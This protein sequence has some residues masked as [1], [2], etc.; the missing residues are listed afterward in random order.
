[1]SELTTQLLD[2]LEE[3]LNQRQAELLRE[4]GLEVRANNGEMDW[5]V[6]APGGA[7]IVDD[8]LVDALVDLNLASI[9]RH[10]HELRLIDEARNRL[11]DGTWASATTVTNRLAWLAY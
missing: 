9:E 11:R 6:R 5:G 3:Q 4:V 1:M 8:G 7:T 2:R 10:I